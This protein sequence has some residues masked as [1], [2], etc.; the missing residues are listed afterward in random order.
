MSSASWTCSMCGDF[1]VCPHAH[2]V[3]RVTITRQTYSTKA[4]N[5]AHLGFCLWSQ[6]VQNLVVQSDDY[7]DLF[8]ARMTPS[9]CYTRAFRPRLAN[10]RGEEL[11]ASRDVLF[12]KRGYYRVRT[13]AQVRYMA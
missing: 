12:R 7:R 1:K 13:S 5:D 9:K 2:S 8:V 3:C 10:W 11:V 6:P 4:E